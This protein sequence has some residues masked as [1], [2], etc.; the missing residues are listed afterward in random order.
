[1]SKSLGKCECGCGG[2]VSMAPFSSRKKGW[3]RGSPVRFISGH[4]R[5]KSPQAKAERRSAWIRDN[6][7]AKSL[8]VFRSR[9][10]TKFGM[11]LDDYLRILKNQGGVCAICGGS[12][13]GR[14]LAVDHDHSTGKVRGVLCSK[15][16]TVLGQA[17]DSTEILEKAICYLKRNLSVDTKSLPS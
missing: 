13:S 4:H 17:R 6:R 2:A 8:I 14:R 9:L 10:K 3:V 11:T 16:N 7:D 12:Q 1:M 15:C 5:R